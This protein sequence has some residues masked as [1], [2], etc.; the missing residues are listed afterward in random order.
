MQGKFRIR[1][2]HRLAGRE[3]RVLSQME[4]ERL[5]V[6]RNLP[7]LGNVRPDLAEIAQIGCHQLAVDVGIDLDRAELI[8]LP[9]SN[10][11]DVVD[12]L[13]HDD[14][15]GGRVGPGLAANGPVVAAAPAA[16]SA[17][18]VSIVVPSLKTR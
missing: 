7:V 8:R 16:I 4:D 15:I 1:R 13:C 9:G 5:A 11:I 14:H 18:R 10:E 12:L 6:R 17:R 2:G 3:Q